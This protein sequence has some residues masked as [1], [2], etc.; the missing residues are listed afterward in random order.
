[1]TLADIIYVIAFTSSLIYLYFVFWLWNGI[2]NAHKNSVVEQNETT[3]ALSIIIAAHNEEN[4]ISFTLD[5]LKGQNYPKEKFEIIMVADRC[6]DAT[7]DIAKKKLN[8][9]AML[10]IVKVEK[11][12]QG[13]TPKKFAIQTAIDTAQYDNLILLDAD[14]QLNPGALGCFNSYFQEGMEAI[15]S[16][17]KFM[18]FPSILYNYYLPERIVTW[19]IAAAAIGNQKPF[20]AF[21]TVWGYS[22][23]AYEI[24]GGM[25]KI[26]HILSGDDD[27]LVYEMG[28]SSLPI[29]F[30]FNPVGWG[31]TRAPHTVA[32]FAKQRRRHHSAGRYYNTKVQ[33][34]YL[35]FHLSNLLLWILPLFKPF[36]IFILA[37]KII[38]DIVIIFNISRIFHEKLNF[39]QGLFFEIG[40][41]L[42]HLFI[43]P[44][45]FVGKIR[46]R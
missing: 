15:V 37:A 24:A 28:K 4:S 6:T 30:C 10:K 7:A 40:Y 43:A 21:G 27:L 18:K 3:S 33:L 25:A 26:S 38:I 41:I 39:I 8:D 45:G 2:K 5:S 23:K 14:C 20:L 13:Y 19:G 1:M 34:G 12:P 44:W 35:I 9:L 31:E 16:I 42:H 17:P 22:K 32:K 11:V 29:A 36:L 46:W